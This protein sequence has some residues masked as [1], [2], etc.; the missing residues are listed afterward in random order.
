MSFSTS[1]IIIAYHFYLR[2]FF[3][4]L[5]WKLGTLSLH[6]VREYVFVE[7]IGISVFR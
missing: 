5:K 6:S 1:I 7:Q 3:S 2:D 4:F